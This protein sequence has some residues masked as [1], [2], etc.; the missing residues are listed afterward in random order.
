MWAP[1]CIHTCVRELACLWVPACTHVRVV[2]PAYRFPCFCLFLALVSSIGYLAAYSPL[3]VGTEPLLRGAWWAGPC[4]HLP[5]PSAG[6]S[7]P[8]PGFVVSACC[9]PDAPVSSL[10]ETP[11]LP[12]GPLLWPGLHYKCCLWVGLCGPGAFSV[13]M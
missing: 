5:G 7:S 6:S 1:V 13:F 4:T 8:H 10:S 12:V 3:P 9:R 2:C 11:W